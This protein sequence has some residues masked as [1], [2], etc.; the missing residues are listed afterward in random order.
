MEAHVL[1]GLLRFLGLTLPVLL[2]AS[3]AGEITEEE[4]IAH[5][6]ELHRSV[7]TIDT[8]DDIPPNFATAEVDPGV[9]E[10]RQVTLPKMREGGLDAAFFVVYV[11][12]GERNPEAYAEAKADAIMKFDAIHR[13]A[14]DM[15]PDE[16]EVVYTAD[17]VE[18]ING[19]G[20]LVA[21]ICIENGYVIGRD[22]SLLETYHALGAR[23]I[24]LTHGGHNDIGDSSTPREQLGDEEEEH[25][26][27]SEFGQQV[28]A[29]MNRVG[30][31]VDVS[32]VSKNTMLDAARLSQAPIIAS[33]SATRALADHP[34][35]LDD[36]QLLALRENGGVIQVV[37]LGGFVKVVPEKDAALQALREEMGITG[38]AAF[39][40]LSDD[41]RA[42]Y[43]A[44]RAELDER[45]PPATVADFV[46]H[47]DHAVELIG[48]DHVG[49]SSD[50]DGGGGVVGWNDASETLNVTIELVRRGYTDEEIE[51][52]WGGNLLRVW[53][54]TEAVARQM[55]QQ[56]TG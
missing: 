20:K 36:E 11:G 33:H 52:L 10:G 22:L 1:R 27:L 23:Y 32:H 40:D 28:V 48:I 13:M 29:E 49:I 17:D 4:A 39:R 25:G 41:Q 19:A 34:R 7:I 2:L 56:A 50:F 30:I 5:A 54:Q 31:M 42:E 21:V 55:Q 44:R 18:R 8:H 35:N 43:D 3:C 38:Y 47:I 24:T 37:G 6:T 14:E 9:R 16:I 53:R 26:G 15:Y 46:D 12:Q 45:W 51:K